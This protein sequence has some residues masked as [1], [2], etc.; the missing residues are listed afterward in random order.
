MSL[1]DFHS[2]SWLQVIK[3][4]CPEEDNSL[5]L[6]QVLCLSCDKVQNEID[7]GCHMEWPRWSALA[8]FTL[9]AG[10]AEKKKEGMESITWINLN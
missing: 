1:I 4:R 5:A 7:V 9:S 6:I 3:G 2:A 8:I 10:L